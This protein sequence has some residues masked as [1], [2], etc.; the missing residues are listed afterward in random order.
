MTSNKSSMTMLTIYGADISR[1][2]ESR[3]QGRLNLIT[4]TAFRAA[5]RQEQVLDRSLANVANYIALQI[6]FDSR[7]EHRL[8]A[9]MGVEDEP[10]VESRSFGRHAFAGFA[11]ASLC[12]GLIVGGMFGDVGINADIYASED[13]TIW[14]SVL[15]D[16][17]GSDLG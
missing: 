17:D 6:P 2:P 7:M 13:V 4:S 9:R 14:E 5:W 8:L 15:E 16:D 3:L 12:L 11:A 10:V 1:W